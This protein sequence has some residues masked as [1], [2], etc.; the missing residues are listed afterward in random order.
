MGDIRRQ[1]GLDYLKKK[2]PGPDATSRP[3][4]EF[5][6]EAILAFTPKV[7]Q[8]MAKSSNR[9]AT[10]F[11]LVDN[12]QESVKVLGPV[13]EALRDNGYVNLIADDA[14][15]DSTFRLTD[16]GAKVVAKL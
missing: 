5:F 11:Q 9:T 3:G 16:R 6:Q 13:L 7:L 14:K 10:V 12:L 15:G 8:A 1:L 4:D 2:R